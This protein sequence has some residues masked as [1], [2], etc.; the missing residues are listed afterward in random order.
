MSLNCN[1]CSWRFQITSASETEAVTALKLVKGHAY[2][3]TGVEEVYNLSKLSTV[4]CFVFVYG[5]QI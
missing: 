5:M 1:V 3:V 2:S 4:S